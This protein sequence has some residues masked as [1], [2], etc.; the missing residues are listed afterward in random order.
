MTSSASWTSCGERTPPAKLVK[1]NHFDPRILED[2]N[3]YKLDGC[4]VFRPPHPLSVR[5]TFE[6][7]DL[8][9]ELLSTFDY[10]SHCEVEN[11][12]SKEF[13][14]NSCFQKCI[15]VCRVDCESG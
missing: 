2:I 8:Y 5:R 7:M 3:K 10:C 1:G 12:F 4:I 6:R 9:V 13:I 15:G 14:L 11:I